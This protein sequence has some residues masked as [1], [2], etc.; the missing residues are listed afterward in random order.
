MVIPCVPLFHLGGLKRK[1]Y[2]LIRYISIAVDQI[3]RSLIL[4]ILFVWK[5]LSSILQ[6][7]DFFMKI[8]DLVMQLCHF[9]SLININRQSLF[10]NFFYPISSLTS[11]IFGDTSSISD[12]NYIVISIKMAKLET[13]TIINLLGKCLIYIELW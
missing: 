4:F 8:I 2:F 1:P 3:Q 7:F 13:R 10:S 12:I 6:C 11:L 5:F 9:S